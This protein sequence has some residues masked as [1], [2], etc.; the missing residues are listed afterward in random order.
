MKRKIP[1]SPMTGQAPSSRPLALWYVGRGRAV[2]KC[3]PVPSPEPG[4]ALVRTLWSGLSRGTERLIF[5]GRVSILENERMRAPMQEGDF[6]FPVKYGHCAVGEVEE[7]PDAL[8][9]RTV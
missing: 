2:L 8:M 6:P 1:E 7:R 4:E 5:E 9:G 3:C